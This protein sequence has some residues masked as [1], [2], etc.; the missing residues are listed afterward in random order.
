[1]NRLRWML[2]L[3]AVLLGAAAIAGVAQP[4]PG[5][6]AATSTPRAITVTGQGTVT[7]VPDTAS[8][9]F[10]ADAR[11]GTATAAMAKASADAAAIAAALKG[12]GVAAEKLQTSQIS[13]STLTSND[14]SSVVGYVASISVTASTGLSHAGGVVDAAVGAGATGVSGPSLTV[15]DQTA[16]YKQALQKAVADATEK[17]KALAAAA[18][19]TLGPARSVAEG[20]AP[21][22]I[23]MG[24]KAAASD[25][26]SIEPGTQEID[27][28]VTITFDAR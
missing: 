25:G 13:L 8:F 9:S 18:S 21:T 26:V 15:A 14:G 27:A 3:A 16:L 20:S 1:M 22:P 19:L 28:T 2:L 17:A 10:S 12:A 24:A 7:S 5:R 4:R 11:A 23:V 6:A